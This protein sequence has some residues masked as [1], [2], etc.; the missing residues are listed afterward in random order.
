MS[1]VAVVGVERS[2]KTVLMA[3]LGKKYSKPDEFGIFLSPESQDANGMV[4]VLMEKMRGGKW[5]APTDPNKMEALDWSVQRQSG[6]GTAP[7]KVCDLSFLDYGG[8]IYR[9]TFGDV[10][11]YDAAQH[12]DHVS[13]LREYVGGSDV[14]LV[15]IKLGDV[16]DGSAADRKVQERR[17]LSKSILDKA[18]REYKIKKIALVFTQIDA[19]RDLIEKEGGLQCVYQKYLKHVANV[20]PKI[21]LFGVTAVN[22]VVSDDFGDPVPAPD[23]QSEGLPEL[24]E[25]I[26]SS[27]P[28]Y[29]TFISHKRSEPV[30]I[31]DD[32]HRNL[33]GIMCMLMSALSACYIAVLYDRV[34]PAMSWAVVGFWAFLI[35]TSVG[36]VGAKILEDT[37]RDMLHIDVR[38]CRYWGLAVATGTPVICA[39]IMR[40]SWNFFAQLIWSCSR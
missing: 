7:V 14:L 22:H 31:D 17:W 35:C 20:Y 33:L 34:I 2:G 32:R 26:I 24:M 8:E 19:Y 37:L 18:T 29:E 40:M 10:A 1:K 38:I 30:R 6:Q 12:A 5:P 21:P 9:R 13:A 39:V 16:I 28:G 25:W 4:D 23:F 15:L 36:A 3:A 11:A 27:V